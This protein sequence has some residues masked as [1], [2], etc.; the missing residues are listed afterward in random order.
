MF[1]SNRKLCLCRLTVATRNVR[2]PESQKMRLFY[3]VIWILQNITYATA[4]QVTIVYWDINYDGKQVKYVMY[5]GGNIF[6]NGRMEVEG[7]RRSQAGANTRRKIQV[8]SN[9]G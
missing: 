3:K 1:T 7:R 9:D 6:E 5:V 4:P 2:L 8:Y